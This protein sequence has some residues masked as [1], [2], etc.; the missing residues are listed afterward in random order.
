MN[1]ILIIATSFPP[2]GEKNCER[3]IKFCKYLPQSG[4][5]PHVLTI[6]E[7]GM[8]AFDRSLNEELA[9]DLKIHRSFYPAAVHI[10]TRLSAQIAKWYKKDKVSFLKKSGI[11]KGI[12]FLKILFLERIPGFLISFIKRNIFIP[13]D[14]I[15]WVLPAAI[16]GARICRKN[17]I[18]VIVS[19]APSFS[20]HLAAYLIKKFTGCKWIADYRD[21]WTGNPNYK[22]KKSFR[23]LIE[24]FLDGLLMRNADKVIT[25]SQE[26]KEFVGEAFLRGGNEKIFVLPNGYDISDFENILTNPQEEN[27]FIISHT[28]VIMPSYPMK[29]LF[30]AIFMLDEEIK[31]KI[32]LNLFGYMYSEHKK[33]LEKLCKEMGLESIVHFGGSITRKEALMRQKES[34]VLLLMYSG[35][36]E[37]VKG[38]IP[39]K[40]FDYIACQKPILALLPECRASQIIQEG[41]CGD[42]VN[43]H[44]ADEIKVALT[45][46]HN[47]KLT[48]AQTREYN[49][50][51]LSQFKR[52]AQTK[53]L[54]N[55]IDGLFERDS[56]N[57]ILMIAT[58]FPPN[59]S[60]GR[61]R[62]VKF[63]KFL[64]EFGWRPIVLAPSYGFFWG[65][66]ESL[67]KE[68]PKEAKVCRAFFPAFIEI[69][70]SLIKRRKYSKTHKE[71][72]QKGI[73]TEKNQSGIK[74]NILSMVKSCNRVLTRFFLVPD[75]YILWVPFAFFK[76][77]RI[78][79]R[80]KVDVIYTSI[81]AASLVLLG[82]LL[83]VALGKKWIIDYR[84]LWSGDHTRQQMKPYRKKIEKFIEVMLSSKA[85]A[86]I[87]TSPQKVDYLRRLLTIMNPDRIFCITNGFDPDDYP[88][89]EQ[90]SS[91]NGKCTIAYTGRLYRRLS[92]VSFLKALGLAF[93]DNPT[94]RSKVNV[95]FIGD[96]FK[97]EKSKLNKIIDKYD[98]TGV[99]DFVGY[100]S[101]REALRYQLSSDALL[102]IMGEAEN[103]DGVI[104][105]KIFEYIG[106]RKPILAIVPQGAAQDIIANTGFGIWAPPDDI[107]GIKRAFLKL[108]G[109]FSGGT[110]GNWFADENKIT[111]FSRRNLTLNLNQILHKIKS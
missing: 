67:L 46:L 40:L 95:Q 73:K 20:S 81:P 52:E 107:E 65:R 88:H 45:N 7:S 53:T 54:S 8:T 71:I 108:Y 56:K 12:L 83:K 106:S 2:V 30:E 55:I 50:D 60:V 97:E 82:F 89:L 69:I 17:K 33:K 63:A 85:D 39:S 11:T 6:T 14:K 84:D 98:L 57:K 51:Y 16:R 5:E 96:I 18:D 93:G 25:V 38:M 66:D 21:L 94:L 62:T 90:K 101:Y 26:W 15:V 79:R 75:Q 27:K 24:V 34:D 59:P 28:G 103:A 92:A 61:L 1:K 10:F 80:E 42:V 19:S 87:T 44:V 32:R 102:L 78:H 64:P 36:G 49:W 100:I 37:N 99:V 86:I 43:A 104:P 41:N 3:V 74:K 111:Q 76:A 70:A 23:R 68:I 91:D 48:G 77:L 58:D 109:A 110:S 29:E 47:A 35:Y 31:N 4:W 105:T 13:D 72:S 9:P 22:V